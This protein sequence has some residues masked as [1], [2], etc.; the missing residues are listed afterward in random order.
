MEQNEGF[1]NLI[2]SYAEKRGDSN[3]QDII[4]GIYNFSMA[5]PYPKKWLEDSAEKFN[6]DDNFDFSKSDWAKSIL[7]G[8]ILSWPCHL[9]NLKTILKE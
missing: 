1:L 4:L 8:M 2:E 5:S 3:V 7:G 9:L 6:I